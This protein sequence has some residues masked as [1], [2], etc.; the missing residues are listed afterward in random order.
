MAIWS[1]MTVENQYSVLAMEPYAA[2]SHMAFLRGLQAH[3]Q[4]RWE[5]LTLPPR[6]WKWRMRT[7]ALHFAAA[8]AERPRPDLLFVTD[9]LNL[10]EMKALLP[11][12]LRSIPTVL[13]FHENQLTYPLHDL[14]RRDFHFGLTHLYAILTADRVYFNSHYHRTRFMDAL[15]EVLKLVPDVR[16]DTALATAQSRS[17]VLPLGVAA[18]LSA[19]DPIEPLSRPAWILW[20]HRWEYDKR[21][22]LFLA[23]LRELVERGYDFR[24]RILGQRFRDEHPVLHEL[25]E[26][27]GP[28]LH[29][30]GFPKDRARYFTLLQEC[31]IVVSTAIH[32]Y[33]GHGVLEAIRAGAYPVLPNDL[34]YPELIPPSLRGED[35]PFLYPVEAGVGRALADA[36][37]TVVR[38]GRREE[39]LRLR[40]ETERFS[41]PRLIHEYDRILAELVTAHPA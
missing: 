9:Y 11:A 39:R 26:L 22:E 27:L 23:G 16:T 20:N 36:L 8:L 35:S 37:E 3:S 29:D 15:T 18:E 30:A 21:P 25:R 17:G 33:F 2:P 13:Y 14:E 19:S 40:G 5:L 10:A 38:G 28:R 12:E 1:G 24:V 4:H 31:D 32:E 41:W 6:K 34:A 7:S